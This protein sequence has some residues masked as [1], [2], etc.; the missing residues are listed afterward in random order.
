MLCSDR[1]GQAVVVE[2]CHWE[3]LID[4]PETCFMG[5]A[6]FEETLVAMLQ[7]YFVMFVIHSFYTLTRFAESNEVAP[8]SYLLDTPGHG[9]LVCENANRIRTSHSTFRLE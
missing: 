2:K 5:G 3:I 1:Q 7:R 9:H 8:Y 6:A 4:K